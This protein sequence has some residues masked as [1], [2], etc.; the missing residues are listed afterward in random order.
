MPRAWSTGHSPVLWGIALLPP[1]FLEAGPRMCLASCTGGVGGCKGS[2]LPWALV[3]RPAGTADVHQTP[4]RAASRLG[5]PDVSVSE[6]RAVTR[7]GWPPAAIPTHEPRS[8][9][10]HSS[11]LSSLCVCA[12]RSSLGGTKC[13]GPRPQQRVPARRGATAPPAVTEEEAGEVGGGQLRDSQADER[14]ECSISDGAA[15]TTT[16]KRAQASQEIGRASC[17]ERVSSPV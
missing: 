17:G 8:P 5:K 2:G 12:Q 1:G 13:P 7:R 4:T 9:S 15:L 3:R 10:S 11:A 14:P 16:P 6:P